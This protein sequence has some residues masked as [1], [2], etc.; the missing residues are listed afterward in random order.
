MRTDIMHAPFLRRHHHH[1]S[2]ISPCDYFAPNLTKLLSIMFSWDS[3]CLYLSSPVLPAHVCLNVAAGPGSH[4]GY[5]VAAAC[6]KPD[7]ASA[8]ADHYRRSGR[9]AIR[10][11]AVCC[12]AAGMLACLHESIHAY[13][14]ACLPFDLLGASYRSHSDTAVLTAC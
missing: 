3:L 1:S 13:C 12:A 9:L 7:R 10:G 2:L 4:A 8:G 5:G 14:T 11:G 6:G